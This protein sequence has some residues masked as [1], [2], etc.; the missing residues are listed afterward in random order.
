MFAHC[1]KSLDKP[2][3]SDLL[4]IRNVGRRRLV[5]YA[6]Q[7]A[8][9]PPTEVPGKRRQK[10]RTFTTRTSISREKAK[11]QKATRLLENAYA[12]L[13]CSGIALAQTCPLPLAIATGKGE[14]RQR[15][16]KFNQTSVCQ[17]S[18]FGTNLCYYMLSFDS[19]SKCI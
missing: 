13:I 10:F 6:R 2:T 1:P 3:R 17:G 7:Y 19:Q 16:Q 8:L 11:V 5:F 18:C 15:P 14:I 4:D 12:H 9:C